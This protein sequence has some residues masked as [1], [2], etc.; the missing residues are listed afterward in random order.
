MM[1]GGFVYMSLYSKG[2]ADDVAGF[3]NCRIAT[4]G[5]SAA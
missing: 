2:S 1:F 3:N 5:A 4:Y